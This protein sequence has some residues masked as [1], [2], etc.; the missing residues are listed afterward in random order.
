MLKFRLHP[1]FFILLILFALSKKFLPATYALMAVLIHE[2][3]HHFVARK[4]GYSL[5]RITL[6]PYGAVIHN[7]EIIHKQDAFAISIAGIVINLFLCIVII[8]CWWIYPLLYPITIT[9]FYANFY[10]A[11]FNLLPAYPLDGARI[12]LSLSKNARKS[13]KT[14]KVLGII[15]SV[16]LLSL[17]IVSAFYHIN[18]TI[19]ILAIALFIGAT[20]GTK[21]EGYIHLAEQIPF[22]KD[23][24]HPVEEI[25]LRVNK[26]LEL[27]KIYPHFN[28]NKFINIKIVDENGEVIN[29]YTERELLS[30]ISG[31]SSTET[32]SKIMNG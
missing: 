4:R 25:S 9:F 16:M 30:H 7:E 22:V 1:L 28:K 26:N 27:R 17:F 11:A 5:N 18:F 12:I 14:L 19:G 10:I 2:Y 24:L 6:M 13:I 23:K 29:K 32:I 21:Q 8:A 20:L 3:A 15:I 31:H